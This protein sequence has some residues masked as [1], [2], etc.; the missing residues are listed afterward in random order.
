MLECCWLVSRQICGKCDLV[1]MEIH[2][3]IIRFVRFVSLRKCVT[4]SIPE[5]ALISF[6]CPSAG[7]SCWVVQHVLISSDTS[8]FQSE[9]VALFVESPNSFWSH[10]AHFL[11]QEVRHQAYWVAQCRLQFR[12]FLSLRRCVNPA[13]QAQFDFMINPLCLS[14]SPSSH[15]SSSFYA[16]VLSGIVLLSECL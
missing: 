6:S 8:R 10:G 4:S 13:L 5:F 14:E 9:C 15:L 16:N 11:S 12:Q 3:N 7:A 2:S 1:A